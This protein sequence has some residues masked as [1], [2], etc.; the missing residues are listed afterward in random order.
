MFKRLVKIDRDTLHLRMKIAAG[1]WLLSTVFRDC[2]IN[3][4]TAIY[5]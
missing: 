4:K 5:Q 1:N 2:L 3:L